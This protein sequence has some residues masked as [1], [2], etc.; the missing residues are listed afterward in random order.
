MF[1]EICGKV[2]CELESKFKIK[3]IDEY[4]KIFFIFKIILKDKRS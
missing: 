1:R 2:V 3:Y 4:I